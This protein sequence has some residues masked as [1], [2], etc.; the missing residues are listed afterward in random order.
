MIEFSSGHQE[1]GN[2]DLRSATR[3]PQQRL[4][5]ELPT[6]CLCPRRAAYPLV[7]R[8]RGVNPA[9]P[10]AALPGLSPGWDGVENQPGTEAKV[11]AS[12]PA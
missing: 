11:S 5:S 9:I 1:L 6:S 10:L 4:V 2:T 12:A 7:S 3:K 8:V